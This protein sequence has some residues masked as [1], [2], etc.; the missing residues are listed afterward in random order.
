[1]LEHK[2]NR[3]QITTLSQRM[4]HEAVQTESIELY[5]PALKILNGIKLHEEDS[6]K[7]LKVVL[8]MFEELKGMIS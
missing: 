8:S 6:V 1:M 7:V 5:G 2:G 3:A 4:I